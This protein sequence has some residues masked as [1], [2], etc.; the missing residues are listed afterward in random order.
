ML[1]QYVMIIVAA[2][3]GLAIGSFLNVC[4]YRLPRQLSLMGRS[5]CPHC[6]QKVAWYD[7]IPLFSFIFLKGGCRHCKK[8]I[9][10]QY[11]LVELVTSLLS[12][13]AFLK[14]PSLA[15]YFAWFLLFVCPLIV[16]AV[17]DISHRIIPDI[18]SLPGILAGFVVAY[19]FIAPSFTAGLIYSG[20]GLLCGGGTLFVL[21]QVYFWIRKREGMGGGDVKL[22]AML[23]A[24]LGWKGML[25][26]FL[27]S[28]ILAILYALVSLI[29]A[30]PKGVSE[31]PSPGTTVIPYGPFLALAALIFHFYGYEI[32]SFYFSFVGIPINPVF[33]H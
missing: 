13:L 17:I 14:S 32:T 8:K 12:V 25:F 31:S 26:V 18:L 3:F 10:W 30:R 4:I 28:S 23:G 21:G 24:F 27:I 6:C 16:V 33:P 29:V 22:S 9:S 20:L 2:L 19:F 5:F 1:P 7:N 15:A 11:P